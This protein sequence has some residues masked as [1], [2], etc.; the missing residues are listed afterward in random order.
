MDRIID[1]VNT[2]ENNVYLFELDL[3]V[4]KFIL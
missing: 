1:T 3:K 4:F 2:Y